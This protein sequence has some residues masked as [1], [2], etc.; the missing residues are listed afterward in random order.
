MITFF[1][2][3]AKDASFLSM[4][5]HSS[6]VSIINYCLLAFVSSKIVKTEKE[7]LLRCHPEA[8]GIFA[9]KFKDFPKKKE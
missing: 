3:V 4:N 6:I 9:L 7:M 8:R 2:I 1:I 5:N